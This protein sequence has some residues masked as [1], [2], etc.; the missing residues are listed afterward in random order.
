MDSR[1]HIFFPPVVKMVTFGVSAR[2]EK[3]HFFWLHF[4]A[5]VVEDNKQLILEGQHHVILRTIGKE[6]FSQSQKQVMA[7]ARRPFWPFHVCV[8]LYGCASVVLVIFL[9]YVLSLPLPLSSLFWDRVCLLWLASNVQPLHCPLVVELEACVA[10]LV[11]LNILLWLPFMSFIL[12]CK[13]FFQCYL[14][15]GEDWTLSLTHYSPHSTTKLYL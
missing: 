15:Y 6:A 11:C 12:I 7:V 1:C 3:W 9:C 8:W 5:Y 10:C 13:N 14:F 2:S 4:Q